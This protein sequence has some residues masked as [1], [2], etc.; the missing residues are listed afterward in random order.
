MLPACAEDWGPGVNLLILGPLEVRV[1]DALVPLGGAKP[2]AMLAAL[3]LHP[4]QVVS[5]GRLTDALWAGQPPPSAAANIKTY[6]SQLR[7]ALDS[8]QAASRLETRPPGYVFRVEPD[9]LDLLTFETLAADGRSAMARGDVELAV[10]QL[11]QT[12]SL[13]RGEVCAD[14]TLGAELDVA[15]SRL[16]EQRLAVTEDWLQARLHRGEHREL[17]PELRGLVTEHPLRE[18]LWEY[19]MIALSSAGLQADALAAYTACRAV[20]VRELGLEPGPQLRDLQAAI[21]ANDTPGPG[22]PG[23][24]A[25]DKPRRAVTGRRELVVPRELPA[26]VPH[27]AGRA[28]ELAV[29]TGLAD[30]TNAGA[31]MVVIS[32][33]GGTAGVGKTALAVHWA[34]QVAGRFGDGQL[35]VN[36]RGFDPSGVP[37][38]PAE[39]IR[40]FLDAL[41]VPAGQV[42]A[43]PEAQQGL[44][45]SLLSGR[46]MLIVLDNA[47]D[48]DQVR[49]LLPATPATT[50]ASTPRPS[51]AT[52]RPWL[53]PESRVT[54]SGRPRSS[55][56]SAT[57]T[58][59]ATSRLRRGTPGSRP[60]TSW[61]TC[62]TP[63]PTR[64][65]PG[66][67]RAHR[68]TGAQTCRQRYDRAGGA[69]GSSAAMRPARPCRPRSAD[70]TA[71][72]A[73]S[74]V[75]E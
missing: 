70:S 39:A 29:L 38:T 30:Q 2:R 58:M 51:P 31:G 59:S 56:I 75:A 60:W 28:G 32:A 53:S 3:L 49:P 68:R 66:S 45:R 22:K 25:A 5:A 46:R 62:I 40:L 18:R 11:G 71:A 34:H 37:V 54:A 6:A 48:A 19:L 69:D 73:T 9:E 14:I 33:I 17:V 72:M 74:A 26:A 67:A 24:A 65:A 52:S 50:S 41:G 8:G 21:L 42:P 35:Y 27:F 10:R 16:D 43:S 44:Y 20:F 57:A 12:L 63:A 23:G 13:W 1:D 7:K 36:L 4:G 55:F 15:R 47:R 61:T 64:F